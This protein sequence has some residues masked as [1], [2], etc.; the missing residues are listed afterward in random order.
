MGGSEMSMAEIMGI[1]KKEKV[2]F[3]HS[4][5]KRLGIGR[6]SFEQNLTDLKKENL[7]TVIRFSSINTFTVISLN[8]K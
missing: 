8:E 3:Y 2:V 4:L 5:R 7:I 6:R 1:L